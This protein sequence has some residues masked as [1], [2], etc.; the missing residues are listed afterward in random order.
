MPDTEV[1][2]AAV[3]EALG[4][5]VYSI[6]IGKFP[7]GVISANPA[8]A[9]PDTAIIL[10]VTPA[11]GYRLKE[12]SLK[13]NG[14]EV[15]GSGNSY[16]FF[17]PQGHVTVT[18]EFELIPDNRHNVNIPDIA[19]GSITAEPAR[20]EAGATVALSISPAG[21]YA[22]KEG[23]LAVTQAGGG[24]VKLNGS[25][26]AYSFAMPDTDVT[27]AAEF[28]ELP[29]GT[30]TVSIGELQG[31]TINADP[32]SAAAGTPVTLT[33][34]PAAGYTL[35]AGTVKVNNGAV[36]VNGS[37][38]AYTFAMP[39]GNVTVTAEFEAINYSVTIGTLTNGS[40]S[41]NKETATVG[42]TITLTVTPAGGYALKAGSL[43]VNNGAVNLS[44]SGN[45]YT[46]A[47]PAA[48]AAVS[49]EFEAINY[50]IT[51]ADMTHGSVTADKETATVGATV[52]L[53]VAPAAG[54]QLKSG[55]P[56]VNGG[57]A[58][59]SGN[60]RTFAM[61]QGNVTVT[62]EFEAIVY[63]ITI[64][65]MTNGS[66]SAD[67][68]SAAAGTV[69]TLTVTP[70]QGY[71]LKAD[72]LKLNDGDVAVSAGSGTAHTFTMPL[73]NVT[74]T[75]EFEVLPS[76]L[77][78][79]RIDQAVIHGTVEAD[80]AE[81]AAG[82]TITL[83]TAPEAGY[84]LKADSLKVNNGAISL[85]GT[86]PYTFAMPAADVTVT[87]E[88]EAVPYSV[89]IDDLENGSV[90]PNTTS[91][92]V[93]TTVSLTVTPALGY[94]LK[95][96][97]LKVN[98]G[99]VSL[100][101]TGPYT[102]AMP[103]GDATVSAAFEKV[104]YNVTI[105]S[106]TNGDISSSMQKA[107][108]GETIILTVTPGIGY[109]LK[110]G[111]L[112]VNGTITPSPSNAAYTF[113]MP[114]A[115]AVVTA[116]FELT[117]YAISIAGS[118]SHG[119]IA[120]NKE[121]AKMGDTVTLTVTPETGYAL[122]AGTLKINGSI[123]PEGSGPYTFVMPAAEVTVTAVFEAISYNVTIGALTNGAI[124][125][126]KETATIG[127]TVT[128]TAAPDEGY[129][130][131]AGTL[132]VN[133]SI[134]PNGSG[135]YTFAMPA[136]AVT[137]T[138]EFEAVAYNIA[139]GSLS[140]GSIA[141]KVGNSP[142][143]TATMGQTVTLTVSPDGGGYEYVADSLTVTKAGGGAV[144][145]TP[146]TEGV[147][148][149]AMPAANVT[150]TA[151]FAQPSPSLT[152]DLEF[153]AEPNG[154]FGV[155]RTDW[156]GEDA[157]QSWTLT[158]GEEPTAYFAVTKTADQTITVGG[159]NG[160]KVEA[161]TAAGTTPE[162]F[163][164]PTLDN[165]IAVFAVDAADLIFDGNFDSGNP[166]LVFTLVAAEGG[167][168]SI[169]YTVTLKPS[170]DAATTA[171]IYQRKDGRWLKIRNP[172]FTTE[173]VEYSLK[174]AGTG[175]VDIIY[176]GAAVTDLETAFAWVCYNAE[177]GTGTGLVGGTTAGFSE[178]RIFLKAD[179]QIGPIRVR[180]ESTYVSLELYGAG[181]PGGAERTITRNQQWDTNHMLTNTIGS[182]TNGLITLG[183]TTGTRVFTFI[184]GKNV[185]LDGKNE[186]RDET[187]LNKVGATGL[188]QISG[189]NWTVIMRDHA[190]ITGHN[191]AAGVGSFSPIYISASNTS[192]RA[193]F[194][195]EGGEI[196]GNTFHEGWGVAYM[197]GTNRNSFYKTGGVI[198]GN[199]QNRV[200]QYSANTVVDITTPPP[201]WPGSTQ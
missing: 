131:K 116:E 148:T 192:Y 54:Y 195:M 128:L 86:G 81:A 94:G 180:F 193:I 5:G 29:E 155:T 151:E 35:K 171:S 168:A 117:D 85:S 129:R 159:T 73:G 15:A 102:F 93:G 178:Y 149:F 68:A 190:K 6:S 77:H 41:A 115:D 8:Q 112:K 123:T 140:N 45:A 122:K 165:T 36:A 199:T 30:Y 109:K 57:S 176:A 42:T 46:F 163:T 143:T 200:I 25:G 89:T 3:F 125:P 188:L 121:T 105:G 13:V 17:M 43:K 184:L 48:D 127:E 59:G 191:S 101:G 177:A 172:T 179:Q 61:P 90:S 64:G 156:Q 31:G 130:L 183:G 14:G 161:V 119:N 181:A 182:T 19:N 53:T 133:D 63:S 146:G 167:K 145:V 18:G 132:K 80:L 95:A 47:M 108:I 55:F 98:N 75:A 153:P 10:T 58:G 135:P 84:A 134:T 141:A 28:E 72:T 56:K 138:A 118:V 60:T 124:T 62:A 23:T 92:A 39:E 66:V 110:A 100:S 113:A 20:A 65:D 44:G 34:T 16:T 51:I 107:T 69:V 50:S 201:G 164:V 67:P 83:T 76:N 27:V 194:Y 87:A 158:A 71:R 99:A 96:D 185:T 142:A 106:L 186:M 136:A 70:S 79:V 78:A 150:V 104:S 111:T 187:S 174:N 147:Y 91:A 1:T 97:S 49:A 37:G 38:A 2:V 160:N 144:T 88:F 162:G 139:I 170:L 189:Y 175:L 197:A 52:A 137:V 154:H 120:T 26:T 173:N 21:G 82:V 40:V 198:T 157:A 7:G 22:L 126:D 24:G 74:V 12:G 9:E 33:A 114:G 32:A 4:E 152:A 166:A 11:E 169:T 196:S 103:A